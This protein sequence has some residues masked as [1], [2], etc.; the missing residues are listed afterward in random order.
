MCQC[1]LSSLTLP[2]EAAIPPCAAT[3]CERVGNTL[4]STAT[5]SPACA[6]CNAARIPEP[7]APTTTTSNVLFATAISFSL[8]PD[9]P[10]GVG[11]GAARHVGWNPTYKILNSKS[12]QYLHRPDRIE[13]QR[14]YH[15]H[16][17]DQ[18]HTGRLDVI[19]HDVAYADPRVIEQAQQKQQAERAHR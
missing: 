6:N 7:P 12:P 9:Y 14:Q 16:M 2:S 13:Q 3:V 4:D 17:D 5:F 1:Q 18:P 10:F 19:H 15:Q 11:R 8:M